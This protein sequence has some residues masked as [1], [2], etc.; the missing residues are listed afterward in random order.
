MTQAAP[1][2]IRIDKWLWHA[3]FNKTRPLAQK[4][5]GIRPSCG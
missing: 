2:R 5:C 4:A 1:E 3:R